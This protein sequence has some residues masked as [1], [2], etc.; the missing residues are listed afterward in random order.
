MAIP[1]L[2]SEYVTLRPFT[3]SDAPVVQKLAGAFEVADT[4]LTIP[5]PY[6]DGAAETWIAMHEPAFDAGKGAT[7]AI[8]QEDEVKGAI[9]LMSIEP[10]HQA[11]LG[12][13]VGVPY[14]G[15]GLC[16]AAGTLV[17]A[18][19]FS[20]LSLQRLHARHLSRN[21]ASGRVL[22]KLGFTHEGSRRGHVMKWGKLEDVEEYGLMAE[23]AGS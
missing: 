14:W 9:S 13:W 12:Y 17:V 16:T 21:P 6:A 7:F 19:A 2:K 3:V 10:D 5:H 1:T 18:F 23:K 20:S 8:V 4:T 15:R 22:R 11:E